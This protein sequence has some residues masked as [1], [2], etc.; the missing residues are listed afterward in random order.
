V[1]LRFVEPDIYKRVMKMIDAIVGRKS[2]LM[3]GACGEA[4]RENG[5]HEHSIIFHMGGGSEFL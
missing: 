3:G 4:A 5:A 1:G 2:S